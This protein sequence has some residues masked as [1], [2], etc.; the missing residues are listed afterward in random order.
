M[1]VLGG[2]I[3]AEISAVAVNRAIFHQSVALKNIHSTDNI[4]AGKQDLVFRHDSLGDG[5]LVT[6][7][8]IGEH[9]EYGK[10]EQVSQHRSLKP[11]RRNRHRFSRHTCHLSFLSLYPC[12]LP[13]GGSHSAI[14]NLCYLKSDTTS[15]R[16]HRAQVKPE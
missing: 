13:E 7:N 15:R 5:R 11:K 8:K 6:I 14:S 12:Q 16:S 1:Q 10:T 9:A 4:V 2:K 3:G